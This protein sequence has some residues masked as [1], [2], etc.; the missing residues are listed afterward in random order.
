MQLGALQIRLAT[1]DDSYFNITLLKTKRKITRLPRAP[2]RSFELS[3][4]TKRVKF[5]IDFTVRRKVRAP[6]L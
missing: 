2:S 1:L 3:A 5:I 6:V 4:I